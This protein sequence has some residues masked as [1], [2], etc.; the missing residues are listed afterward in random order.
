MKPMPWTAPLDVALYQ[1]GWFASVSAAAHDLTWV[2]V[3]AAGS[4]TAFRLG[5]SHRPGAELR[6][7][8]PPFQLRVRSPAPAPAS[9]SA[10]L[11]LSTGTLDTTRSARYLI[12]N[13][14]S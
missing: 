4:L 5:L 7:A 3:L 2:G 13:S 1:L 6:R 10:L 8:Q 14:S 11:A 12:K 9:E